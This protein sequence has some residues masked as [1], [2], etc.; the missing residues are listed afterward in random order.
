MEW[1]L[2]SGIA[3]VSIAVQV[4]VNR[5]FN[6]DGLQ[7]NFWR[8]AFACLLLFVPALLV[9]WPDDPRVYGLALL[10]GIASIYTCSLLFNLAARKQ[11]RV[12][13]LYSPMATLVGLLLWLA[14]SEAEQQRLAANPAAGLII[15]IALGIAAYGLN[16]FRRNDASWDTLIAVLPIGLIFGCT[17]VLARVVLAHHAVLPAVTVFCFLAFGVTAVLNGLLLLWR[18]SFA[19][20]SAV[21]LK[22]GGVMATASAVSF[23]SLTSAVLKGPNPA[24]PGFLIMTMPVMLLVYHRLVGVRDA[25]DWRGAVLIVIGAVLASAQAVIFSY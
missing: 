5:T 3:A 16:R 7:L 17:D 15:L 8:A 12:S 14:I 21:M 11:S 10:D 18:K 20:P 13:S 9:T 22:C 4:E 2:F 24:Y 1:I 6:C 25:A 23:L 19:R